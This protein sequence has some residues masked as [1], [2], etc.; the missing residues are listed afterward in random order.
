MQRQNPKIMLAAALLLG[1]I[2]VLSAGCAAVAVGAVAAAGAGAAVY[3]S[4]DLE[5]DV[6]ANPKQVATATEEAFQ[7]LSLR[8]ISK[9]ATG[10]DAEVRARTAGDE[11]VR[12]NVKATEGGS[13]IS[14]RVGLIGDETL[15]R[16]IYD[17]IRDRLP[18][19][20]D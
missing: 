13:H 18:K 1:L 12:V 20:K 9:H 6:A 7:Q 8:L 3:V 17:A 14:I 5:A 11:P 2:A 19:P 10:L 15:S 4:G 16:K